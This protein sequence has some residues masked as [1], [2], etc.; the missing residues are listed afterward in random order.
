MEETKS[1][2]FRKDEL[3]RLHISIGISHAIVEDPTL[4]VILGLDA[5]W[6]WVPKITM[7]IIAVQAYRL[8]I[9][10][11]ERLFHGSTGNDS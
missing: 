5:F 2:S 6:M 11:R 9:Y 7:S 10:L 1:Q 4:F 3:E 8:Y